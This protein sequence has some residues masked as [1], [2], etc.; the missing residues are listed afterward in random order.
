MPEQRLSP[1]LRFVDCCSCRWRA[2]N[3][4]S[5][6]SVRSSKCSRGRQE[7]RT[8]LHTIVHSEAQAKEP[9]LDWLRD[10]HVANLFSW[11]D[12]LTGD[13]LPFPLPCLSK[14]LLRNLSLRSVSEQVLREHFTRAACVLETDFASRQ[15]HQ[16]KPTRYVMVVVVTWEDGSG[17]KLLRVFLGYPDEAAEH[18]RLFML[19]SCARPSRRATNH[20]QAARPHEERPSAEVQRDA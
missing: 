3:D 20:Q 16:V 15:L 14:T 17:P 8:Y 11:V 7:W 5:V 12:L 9:S 4:S 19:C 13:D 18:C 10:K 2:R 1:A 6:V